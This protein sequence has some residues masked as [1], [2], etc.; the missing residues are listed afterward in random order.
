ML[1]VAKRDAT[2]PDY[3]GLSPESLLRSVASTGGE[4]KI[5]GHPELVGAIPVAW[6][7]LIADLG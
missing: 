3:V 5:Q 6:A 2:H 1:I 4:A 7:V